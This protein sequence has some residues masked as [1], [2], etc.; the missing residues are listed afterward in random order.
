MRRVLLISGIVIAVVFAV[1]TTI[2]RGATNQES[3][4]G[5]KTQSPSMGAKQKTTELIVDSDFSADFENLLKEKR[6]K[7]GKNLVASDASGSKL[8]ANVTKD[9]SDL[10]VDWQVTDKEDRRIPSEVFGIRKQG[11]TLRSEETWYVCTEGP[12]GKRDCKITKCVPRFPCP[13]WIC[14]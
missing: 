10:V 12:G 9:G 7:L 6:L 2:V 14:G 8:W 4:S 11:A 1:R 5:K 3:A 13:I